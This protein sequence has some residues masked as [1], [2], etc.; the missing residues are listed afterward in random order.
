MV[1]KQEGIQ[2]RA[3]G[4]SL[5]TGPRAWNIFRLVLAASFSDFRPPSR[6][7]AWQDIG[8]GER[9]SSAGAGVGRRS[10]VRHA[11]RVTAQSMWGGCRV[12]PSREGRDGDSAVVEYAGVAARMV[13]HLREGAL[14]TLPG[15]GPR[16]PVV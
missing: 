4:R 13:G 14:G 15:R 11:K 7:R 12:C 2:K 9:E 5:R 10:A 1:G 3:S 16:Q 8:Y 6:T